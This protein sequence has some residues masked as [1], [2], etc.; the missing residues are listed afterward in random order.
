MLCLMSAELWITEAQAR[1]LG[2][3]AMPSCECLPMRVQAEQIRTKEAEAK[4][5]SF[6]GTLQQRLLQL[7]TE[8]SLCSL[9][10]WGHCTFFL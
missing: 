9:L 6:S 7:A 5:A 4:L 10:A 3:E 8:V 2:H 1:S